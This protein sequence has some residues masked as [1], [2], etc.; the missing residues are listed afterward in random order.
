MESCCIRI[1]GQAQQLPV[2][3]VSVAADV[4]HDIA[5]V[6]LTQLFVNESTEVFEVE[7]IFPI[8]TKSALSSL[9]ITTEGKVIEAQV[10]D[11]EQAREQYTDAIAEG[12]QAVLGE[13]SE[14]KDLVILHIGSLQPQS[15]V[16][17][18]VT[19]VVECMFD[20]D[21]WRL[22]VPLVVIPCYASAILGPGKG[23]APQEWSFACSLNSCSP[24]KDVRLNIKHDRRRLGE[25]SLT[26]EASDNQLPNT[27]IDLSYSVEDV[28]VPFTIVQR[29]P[30]SGALGLHFSLQPL[31]SSLS[32][33]DFDP[34]GEFVVLLDRSSSM[35]G[36]NIKTAREAVELFIRSLPEKSLFNIVSFG[37]GFTKLFDESK[38]YTKANIAS[39]IAS[40]RS[41]DA[42]LGGTEIFEPLQDILKAA[43]QSS[44]PRYVFVLTDGEVSNV[45]E[46]THLVEKK[47]KVTRV[48]TIGIGS[49]ASTDLIERVAKAGKGSSTL[50]LDNSQI[51]GGVLR[52]LEKSLQPSLNNIH[53][54]WLSEPPVC[55]SPS[56]PF[57]AFNGER[58]SFNAILSS[59][60][61]SCS[62]KYTDSIDG[63]EKSIEAYFDLDKVT[64]G[65]SAV[66]QAVRGVVGTP[67]E[68]ELAVRFSVLTKATGLIAVCSQES[69]QS[70]AP[71][72]RMK[73]GMSGLKSQAP[74][75][76]PNLMT[77]CGKSAKPAA[78]NS[79]KTVSHPSQV[80][81]DMR[82]EVEAE[83]AVEHHG[84]CEDASGVHEE[85]DKCC[86]TS[87]AMGS[88]SKETM[89]S[90]AQA[91]PASIL[92]SLSE[93]IELQ[94][95][96]G[97]W[98]PSSALESILAS[99]GLALA[100]VHST[101][102]SQV[103]VVATALACAVLTE[104]FAAQE[105][106]WRLVVIKAA[107][108]LKKQGV[109]KLSLAELT[110]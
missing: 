87:P 43:P 59:S 19:Y 35:V 13:I 5:S 94:N 21:S 36:S 66:V 77:F 78:S 15:E 55:V 42:D 4:Q 14:Q 47:H 62:V 98:E 106:T 29:D 109:Q 3:G 88:P 53:V 2:K 37:S 101:Y 110:A 44:Y 27:D 75:K 72:K 105:D 45:D 30:K 56:K 73:V 22:V 86:E 63:L 93:L 85:E 107:R 28:S 74:M 54:E 108:W 6:C 11:K 46:I 7:F 48:S 23:S 79:V 81:M 12:D 71:P 95:P 17:V 41:F 40:V 26:L 51:R 82:C 8:P 89:T 61:V 16:K 104:K 9:R 32:L 52:S 50:I 97:S 34:S 83:R 25:N 38:P 80:Y 99:F 60:P 20:Q 76:A 90:Q 58:V 103:D 24:L 18:E 10:K 49:G 67:Q 70:T 92:S 68:V 31:F 39:A 65:R 69:T 57:Y 91:S 100:Q 102:S 84:G 96:D 33:E 1:V 64:E